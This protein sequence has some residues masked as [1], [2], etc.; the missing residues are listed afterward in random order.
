MISQ[1]G[2]LAADEHQRVAQFPIDLQHV[3][4][5]LVDDALRLFAAVSAGV[6]EHVKKGC[7]S[8]KAARSVW[9]CQWWEIVPGISTNSI[10]TATNASHTTPALSLAD[11]GEQ[12]YAT[13]SN[14]VSLATN[15]TATLTVAGLPG[16]GA[17]MFDNGSLTMTWTNGSTLLTATNLALPVW[18]WTVVTGAT[19]PYVVTN[20]NASQQFYRVKQ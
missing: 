4:H 15:T 19:S 14:A 12:Y 10:S 7:S 16:F 8:V 1:S 20:L 2:V 3:R 5:G 6:G 17:V 13:V 11:N 18:Q 9:G